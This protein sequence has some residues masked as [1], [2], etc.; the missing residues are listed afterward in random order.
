MTT[1]TI[2]NS[3]GDCIRQGLAANG[4][5]HS[6]DLTSNLASLPQRMFPSTTPMVHL[7]EA[8]RQASGAGS[9]LV[10]ILNTPLAG[11]FVSS[12]ILVSYVSYA[13]FLLLLA[14]PTKCSPNLPLRVCAAH[15]VRTPEGRAG[16]HAWLAW[17]CFPA[18]VR[19]AG[20][21]WSGCGCVF[22]TSSWTSSLPS[23]TTSA[24]R[25]RSRS[26]AGSGGSTC[27]Y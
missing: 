18:N 3:P 11:W 6:P 16:A 23:S 1:G 17:P 24:C 22:S 19:H 7:Q 21:L 25:C 9:F 4:L 12:V 27:R 26:T 20:S 13:P 15:G 14:A 5:A 2:D 8:L 10:S